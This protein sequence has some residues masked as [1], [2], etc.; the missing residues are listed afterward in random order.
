MH[1]GHVVYWSMKREKQMKEKKAMH[2]QASCCYS[3]R[4]LFQNLQYLP[5][6]YLPVHIMHICN[7]AWLV[8]IFQTVWS[9]NFEIFE[10]A[11]VYQNMAFDKDLSE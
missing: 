3:K 4:S 8:R 9:C 1:A 10:F 2:G 6:T 5:S 7:A 11:V